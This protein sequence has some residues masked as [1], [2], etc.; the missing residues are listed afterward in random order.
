MSPETRRDGSGTFAEAGSVGSMAENAIKKVR[1][2]V[3]IDAAKR[4]APRL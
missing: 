3:A 4:D 2:G 1:F